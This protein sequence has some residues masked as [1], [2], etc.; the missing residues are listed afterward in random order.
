[1]ANIAANSL[2][3]ALGNL[4]RGYVIVN[5]IGIRVAV[6]PFTNKP[7]VRFYTTKRVGGGV[8]DFHAIKLLKFST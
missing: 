3:I 4:G 5:R 1:M 2:S 6:D 8:N 7:P